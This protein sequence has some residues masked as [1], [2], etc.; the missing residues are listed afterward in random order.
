[1]RLRRR[2]ARAR[3]R[4]AARRR[5]APPRAPVASRRRV[6]RPPAARRRRT[7]TTAPTASSASTTS[8]TTRRRRERRAGAG[9]ADPRERAVRSR[10][11]APATS[12]GTRQS[13]TFVSLRL[14]RHLRRDRLRAVVDARVVP[15]VA[16]GSVE[17]DPGGAGRAG[18]RV[19]VRRVV[20]VA[21]REQRHARVERARRRCRPRRA[22]SAAR[23]R[24]TASDECALTCTVPSA[25][26]RAYGLPCRSSTTRRC[27][28]C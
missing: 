5:A 21:V 15:L 13:L 25:S 19:V 16:A 7:S 3:R 22:G 20:L 8:E 6:C 12:S 24:R 18:R 10:P 4:R 9:L 17:R 28:S 27:R 11:A 23:S 26:R 14:V 1:M 2:R